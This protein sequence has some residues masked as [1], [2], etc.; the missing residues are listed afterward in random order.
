MYYSFVSTINLMS[1]SGKYLY[2]TKDMGKD[3]AYQIISNI[4]AKD[5]GYRYNVHSSLFICIRYVPTHCYVHYL[6]PVQK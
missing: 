4:N 2:C 1:I 3:S 5:C 6:Y